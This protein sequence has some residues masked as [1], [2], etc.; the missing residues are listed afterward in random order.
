MPDGVGGGRG[1]ASPLRG[2]FTSQMLDFERSWPNRLS[3]ESLP[4]HSGFLF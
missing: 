3:S 2:Y 4:V 1:K